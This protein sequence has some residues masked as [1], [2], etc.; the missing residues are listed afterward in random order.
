[1][2]HCLSV[3]GIPLTPPV[4]KVLRMKRERKIM[5]GHKPTWKVFIVISILAFISYRTILELEEKNSLRNFFYSENFALLARTQYLS[6]FRKLMV[7]Y[8][9]LYHIFINIT[10]VSK[11]SIMARQ[12][13]LS[14][15]KCV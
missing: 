10:L 15:A 9:I 6:S 7:K 8:T 5:F 13:P 12:S 14:S 2:E 1:M 4:K 11:V 3:A